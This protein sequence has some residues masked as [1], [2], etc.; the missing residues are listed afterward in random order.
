MSSNT[1]CD[2]CGM[3]IKGPYRTG[4][5]LLIDD[6]NIDLCKVHDMELWKM[7]KKMKLNYIQNKMLEIKKGE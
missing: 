1:I 5:S 4:Q 7:I 3:V 6:H 2:I